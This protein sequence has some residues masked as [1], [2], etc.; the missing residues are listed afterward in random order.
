M[1]TRYSLGVRAARIALL[2]FLLGLTVTHG[3]A[4][5]LRADEQGTG[6]R[7]RPMLVAQTGHVGVITSMAVSRDREWLVTGSQDCTARVWHLTTG[8]LMRSL[9][10]DHPV[11][12]ARFSSDGRH[13]T[14]LTEDGG[15]ASWDRTTGDSVSRIEVGTEL[16]TL[17]E[18]GKWAAVVERTAVVVYDCRLG[19]RAASFDGLDGP[20]GTLSFAPNSSIVAVTVG[21]IQE[22]RVVLLDLKSGRRAGE[23]RAHATRFLE[24][25]QD[26][27]QLLTGGESRAAQRWDCTDPAAVRPLPL[28]GFGKVIAMEY[29][30]DGR[31]IAADTGTTVE[32]RSVET[33]ELELALPEP[34][35]PHGARSSAMAFTPDSR[36]LLTTHG[37][38]TL[39]SLDTQRETVR[40]AS[41][42]EGVYD[43]DVSADSRLLLT[44]CG[45]AAVLWDLR[46]GRQVNRYV[47]S[48]VNVQFAALTGRDK[49]VLVFG[50]GVG[51]AHVQAFDRES[52]RPVE[53]LPI[54]GAE[55]DLIATSVDG[56]AVITRVLG[57]ARLW[58]G[59]GAVEQGRFDSNDRISSQ[60]ALSN[61]GWSSGRVDG[62]TLEIYDW[63]RRQLREFPLAYTEPL[64][65]LEGGSGGQWYIVGSHGGIQQWDGATAKPIRELRGHAEGQPVTALAVSVKGDKL[66]SG[67][68]D[69]TARLWETATGKQLRVFA[70]HRPHVH[71][72]ALSDDERF[73]VTGG[74]DSTTR[75]W[76][77]ATGE[78]LVRLVSFLDGS[79][80]VVDSEGRYDT[81]NG[82]ELEG[83]HWV[84]DDDVIELGQLRDVYYDP[85]LLAKKLDRRNGLPRTVPPISELKLPPRVWVERLPENELVL[86][87]RL[88]NHGGGIG[89]VQI[90][91]DGKPVIND[92]RPPGLDPQAPSS[93]FRVDL[94][95]QSALAP[96]RENRVEVIAYR[97]DAKIRSRGPPL[98]LVVPPRAG[99]SPVA[100]RLIAVVAGVSDYAGEAIRLRYADRDAAQFADALRIAWEGLVG[101]DEARQSVVTVLTSTQTDGR[102]ARGTT[103]WSSRE[104]LR[105][106]L[107]RAELAASYDDVFVLYLSGHGRTV[108]GADGDYFYF[109][110][111]AAS[112]AV[113]LPEVLSQVALSGRELMGL[114]PSRP[115][116]IVLVID[117]CGAGGLFGK[118]G[119][120]AR[121]DEITWD[122]F[123]DGAGTFVLA[124]SAADRLSFESSQYQHGILTYA[125]L[126]GLREGPEEVDVLRWM[127]QV[128]RDVP[129]LSRGDDVRQVPFLAIP[130]SASSF[131]LGRLTGSSRERL[132][133]LEVAGKQLLPSRFGD[134]QQRDPEKLS[135]LIDDR[136]RTASSR[137]LGVDW[138]LTGATDSPDAFQITGTYA[139]V[140]DEVRVDV[141][142]WKGEREVT[143]ARTLTG[144]R[145][146]LDKLADAILEHARQLI[147]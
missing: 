144:S 1:S 75:I 59:G 92:A 81:S 38:A 45:N 88:E 147:R 30:P 91:V 85:G 69:G 80:A 42:S 82:G 22:S 52:G 110:A 27:R 113:E 5:G 56:S 54:Q 93:S 76:D 111:E 32:V 14:T 23:I 46:E 94:T 120:D 124:G 139:V 41:A 100:T 67:G 31:R 141:H 126:K 86:S 114:L 121:V 21:T 8:A 89:P 109:T 43:V 125:L 33:G 7:T 122:R 49:Y 119:S 90:R 112:T 2:M 26:G 115:R 28:R 48:G 57:S 10:H 61:D 66:L 132:P 11:R 103:S 130:K 106:A 137:G 44:T 3:G 99:S 83:L 9:V 142:V 145:A 68:N 134:T 131:P 62:Q 108:G 77:G 35:G 6:H 102:T 138:S 16:S 140:G 25:S 71:A 98:G 146:A 96:G 39:W 40:Y 97:A 143:P 53:R 19:S 87:I 133:K 73:V 135:R 47:A 64:Q 127:S 50:Q 29:S 129:T 4:V 51:R 107:K 24:F 105:D 78:E 104:N 63:R 118:D 116:R 36:S 79:W 60:V 58:M 84:L 15:I 128:Q 34:L 65:C 55:A 101:P 13:I 72:V 12:Q 18:D 74:C 136:I 17:S 95:G 117:T 20:L 123:R 70:H 37:G